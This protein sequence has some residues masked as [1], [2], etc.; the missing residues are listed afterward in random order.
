MGTPSTSENILLT[1][2]AIGT[3]QNRKY[4]YIVNADNQTE[5]REVQIGES[6]NGSRIIKSGLSQGDQVIT[7]GLIRLRPGMPVKPMT[8]EQMQAAQQAQQKPEAPE[9]EGDDAE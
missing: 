2:R 9:P 4:V 1:E 8:K 5:Y 6:I 7:E 3:D